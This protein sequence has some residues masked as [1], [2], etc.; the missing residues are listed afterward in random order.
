MNAATAGV[1]F[2]TCLWSSE[3]M[4]TF[5]PGRVK[6]LAK[7][8]SIVGQFMRGTWCVWNF[9]LGRCRRDG[10]CCWWRSGRTLSRF[11]FS[12][13]YTSSSSHAHTHQSTPAHTALTLSCFFTPYLQPFHGTLTRRCL[14]W[15]RLAA[16]SYSL[17][18]LATPSESC[19]P[20]VWLVCVCVH[21]VTC[22]EVS[23]LCAF[24]QDALAWKSMRAPFVCCIRR[25]PGLDVCAQ[26]RQ[27][28]Q[29][30]QQQQPN[31][32]FGLFW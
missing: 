26:Q 6:W 11:S 9:H 4:M 27:T 17:L 1:L 15:L 25:L 31:S 23:L 18:R 20:R 22:A 7:V 8:T 29:H 2:G 3:N 32:C 10:C 14:A 24:P 28:W 16:L 5:P 12:L 21:S 30:Q 19:L 13:G